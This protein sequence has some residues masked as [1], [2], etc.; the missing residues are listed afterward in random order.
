M[1]STVPSGIAIQ[2]SDADIGDSRQTA[3]VSAR[4]LADLAAAIDRVEALIAA[5]SAPQLDGS[6][7]LE[8]IA[9]IAFVLHERDVEAS[10]CDALDAAVREIAGAGPFADAHVQRLG[11][12]AELLREV[13]RRIKQLIAPADAALSAELPKST[14]AAHK[15]LSARPEKR[16]REEAAGVEVS[17][18]DL[19]TTEMVEGD[20][21]A[22][23]LQDA[24]ISPTGLTE[25]KSNVTGKGPA[26]RAI[27]IGPA[28][29][30][31][32]PSS[33]LNPEDDPGDLFERSENAT[34]TPSPHQKNEPA[35]PLSVPI[36]AGNRVSGQTGAAVDESIGAREEKALP[37]KPTAKAR[38]FS[39]APFV[40]EPE[41][42]TPRRSDAVSLP[43]S[44]PRQAPKDPMAPVRALSEE[45]TI[46]L[47]S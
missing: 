32:A 29:P 38:P 34:F 11:E 46:A 21:F 35:A 14:P 6:N 7:A 24:S 39:G 9:D 15:P 41:Q 45:E 1:M 47:F 36:R 33:E 16:D 4:E 42:A 25:V 5:D 17:V 27:A 40:A 23:R 8:C 44:V 19:F 10:L 43:Q 18:D 28:S 31:D 26:G 2:R 13:S 20:E 12:A 37:A 3:A 30:L 22:G